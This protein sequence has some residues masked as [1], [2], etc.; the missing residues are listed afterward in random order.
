MTTQE[1]RGSIFT[2]VNEIEDKA[3]LKACYDLLKN[4]LVLEKRR[5]IAFTPEGESIFEEDY[6]TEVLE[7]LDEAA[8]GKK[9]SHDELKKEFGIQ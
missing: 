7:A 1:I 3:V 8:K 6:E 2:L 5:V 9:I 4:V